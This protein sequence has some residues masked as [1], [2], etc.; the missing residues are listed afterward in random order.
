MRIFMFFIVFPVSIPILSESKI[1][2]EFTFY[3]IYPNFKK[4][5]EQ[6]I[7]EQSP[8]VKNGIRYNGHTH[9]HVNWTFEWKERNGRCQISEVNTYLTVKYSMPRIPGNHLVSSE[10]RDSFDE[11]YD[12]LFK[13]EQGHRDSGL[14]AAR[15][16]RKALT[17]LG[18]F[19]DCKKLE[20]VANKIAEK[21][22]VKYNKRD[23]DYDKRTNHRQF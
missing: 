11:Y 22:I 9:W 2:T 17:S 20:T 1:R 19:K 14:F 8:I 18:L 15:D 5:L 16:I 13:H 7:R 4:D 12:S 10:A 6:E 3:T 21:I 23:E